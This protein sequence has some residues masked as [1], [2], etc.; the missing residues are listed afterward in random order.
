LTTVKIE[1][2]FAE[3]GIKKSDELPPLLLCCDPGY[4]LVSLFVLK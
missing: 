1:N 4:I 3:Y 2:I